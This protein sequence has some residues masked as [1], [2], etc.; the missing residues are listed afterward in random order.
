ML[1]HGKKNWNKLILKKKEVV[2]INAG[3]DNID[4][5]STTCLNVSVPENARKLIN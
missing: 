1:T 5:A 4:H 3:T 2:E